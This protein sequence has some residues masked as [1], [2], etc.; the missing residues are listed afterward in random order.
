MTKSKW[1][2]VVLLMIALGATAINR[3]I[4][5]NQHQDH[6]HHQQTQQAKK[7][8]PPPLTDGSKNP[9]AIPDFVAYEF[10][11]KS[12]ADGAGTTE[13]ERIRAKLFV[14]KV[15]LDEPKRKML[16]AAANG[17]REKLAPLNAQ[18]KELKDRNWPNP[19]PSVMAQL[20]NL[21][22]Q[23]ER[24]LREQI[25]LL[26]EQLNDSDKEKLNKRL[27]EIK[28]KVKMYPPIP[29]EKFQKR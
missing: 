21:Q 8:L 4:A 23:K 10:L 9:H 16:T 18:A 11:L 27:L 1:V 12:I 13:P 14:E 7:D 26:T 17:F 22:A 20:G 6:Q 5:S 19:S 28:S 29:L 15:G 3:S 2:V 24:A 25:N